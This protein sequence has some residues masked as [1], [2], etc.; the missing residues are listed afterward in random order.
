MFVTARWDRIEVWGYVRFRGGELL[1]RL[2]GKERYDAVEKCKSRLSAQYMTTHDIFYD[3][4]SD[5]FSSRVPGIKTLRVVWLH[6]VLV[7]D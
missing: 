7:S 6:I 3:G 4:H 1:N 5:H 2:C